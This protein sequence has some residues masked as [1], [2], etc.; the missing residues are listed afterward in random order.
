M[1]PAVG[2]VVV[3][4]VVFYVGCDGLDKGVVFEGVHFGGMGL[5]C[6]YG[7]GVGVVV[8]NWS[9]LRTEVVYRGEVVYRDEI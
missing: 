3:T 8:I 5:V 2:G 9:L 7:V 1:V 6:G 4:H